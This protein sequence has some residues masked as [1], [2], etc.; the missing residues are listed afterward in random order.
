LNDDDNS[1]TE[2]HITFDIDIK[3]DCNKDTI[4]LNQAVADD[5]Y[6]LGFGDELYTPTWTNKF[7]GCPKTCS[8]TQTSSATGSIVTNQNAATGVITVNTN[9]AVNFDRI[10]TT[11]TVTC[12]M[13]DNDSATA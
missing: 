1:N 9:D 6:Y 11:I 12:V 5:V 8:Y 3:K 4:A 7:I 2:A 10:D 13:D